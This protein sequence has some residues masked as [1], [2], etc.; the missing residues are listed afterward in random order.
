MPD[1]YKILVMMD[2]S[3]KKRVENCERFSVNKKH[4]DCHISKPFHVI[5]A[6]YFLKPLRYFW[7]CHFLWICDR[8]QV[9][10]RKEYDYSATPIW[11]Q[12]HDQVYIKT[13]VWLELDTY[14]IPSPPPRDLNLSNLGVLKKQQHR[15]ISNA[16]LLSIN[17]MIKST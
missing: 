16:S 2:F 11:P 4:C 6:Y 14:Y 1:L 13:I 5:L 3:P 7:N 8:E 15:R 17:L 9:S 10:G 12:S